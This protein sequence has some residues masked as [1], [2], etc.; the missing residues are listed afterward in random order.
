MK[1][2]NVENCERPVF[3]SG[4]CIL[5]VP[6]KKLK[7]SPLKSKRKEI[8]FDEIEKM[9]SFFLEIWKERQHVSEISGEK[10]IG[11]VKNYYFHHILEK[12]SYPELKYKK[13]N[14]ILITFQE[15]QNVHLDSFRYEEVNKRRELLKIKYNI[16]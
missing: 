9:N 11:E 6:K 3:S 16:I 1:I 8:N 2:C 4:K 7:S 12:Q 10:L 15:H 13:D 14:I 5:H